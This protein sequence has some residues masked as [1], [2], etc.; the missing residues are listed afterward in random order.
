MTANPPAAENSAAQF[1]PRTVRLAR[2]VLVFS[3]ILFTLWVGLM[4]AMY[5]TTVYPERKK[6]NT[7][8]LTSSAVTSNDA[9]EPRTK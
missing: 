1:T 8:H 5:V 4:I 6:G 3:S 2:I 9:K 7:E